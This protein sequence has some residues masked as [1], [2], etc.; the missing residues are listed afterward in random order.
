MRANVFDE[1]VKRPENFV[2]LVLDCG[3]FGID[4]CVNV[5]RGLF[6]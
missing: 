1:D 5:L 3:R 2:L 4:G 6:G